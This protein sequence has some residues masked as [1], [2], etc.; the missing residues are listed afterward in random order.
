MMTRAKSGI[1]KPKTYN[2]N[3]ENKEPCNF[4]EAIHSDKW[5]AIMNEE[6]QDLVNNNTWTLVKL[7]RH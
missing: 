3:L 5:S 1:F 2:V 4:Q 7:P 6:F